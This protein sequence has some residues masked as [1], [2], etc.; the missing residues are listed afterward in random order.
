MEKIY[1]TKEEE[2]PYKFVGAMLAP[3]GAFYIDYSLDGKWATFY[4]VMYIQL[5]QDPDSVVWNVPMWS[6]EVQQY[7]ADGYSGTFQEF[8][9]DAINEDRHVQTC[10]NCQ[11]FVCLCRRIEQTDKDSII[12]VMDNLCEYVINGEVGTTPELRA[13][14]KSGEWGDLRTMENDGTME[15]GWESEYLNPDGTL[16]PKEGI[17]HDMED[18]D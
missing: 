6:E 4:P 1:F 3:K 18:D 13:Y 17:F 5:W 8:I 11:D 9:E 2:C 14:F 16:K 12:L 7:Y 10:L 15:Q